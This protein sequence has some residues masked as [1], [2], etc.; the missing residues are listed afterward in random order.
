M[1]EFARLIVFGF[2]AILPSNTD[3]QPLGIKN[4]ETQLRLLESAQ[5][6]FNQN[7]F[8]LPFRQR[9]TKI[10]MSQE[11]PR[12]PEE[13][14]RNINQITD[15]EHARWAAQAEKPV[16]DLARDPKASPQVRAMKPLLDKEAERIGADKAL[17]KE[18]LLRQPISA[19]QLSS[20]R[21]TNNFHNAAN[22]LGIATV[23]DLTSKIARHILSRKKN[24]SPEAMKEVETW[25]RERGL[26]VNQP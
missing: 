7:F 25:L 16:R 12:L 23:E 26:D 4:P 1:T 15:P 9:K 10:P 13:E 22:R 3:R 6:L 11:H 21:R 20:T 18:E 8:N 24:M 17:I 14:A 5:F 19:I 2:L